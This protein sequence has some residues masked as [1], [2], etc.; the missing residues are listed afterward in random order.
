MKIHNR[1]ITLSALFQS[2][3][4]AK[5]VFPDCLN[6]PE[7]LTTNLV[8]DTTASPSARA[9]ALIKAWNITEKLANIVKYVT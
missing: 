8:C 3:V 2:L 4:K 7:I 1:I 5:L 6:G 9:A